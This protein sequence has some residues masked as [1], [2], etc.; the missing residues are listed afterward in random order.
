MF[1]ELSS[2]VE[3]QAEG[4]ERTV[5]SNTFIHPSYPLPSVASL[6]YRSSLNLSNNASI[7]H[8]RIKKSGAIRLFKIIELIIEEVPFSP[9]SPL[10]PSLEKDR[11]RRL[12]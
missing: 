4:A 5:M 12:P 10:P 7:Y 3:A 8:L 2:S 11:R 1:P 6:Q 9:A